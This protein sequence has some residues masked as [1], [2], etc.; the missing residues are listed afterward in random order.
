MSCS[1]SYKVKTFPSFDRHAKKLTKK[2]PSL[3]ADLK[4]LFDSLRHTPDQG[5]P[6]GK[7]CYKVR[8]P[9]SSKGQGK[10]GGARAITFVKVTR[11]TVFLL[12]LYDKSE[13]ETITAAKG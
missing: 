4:S 12:A 1:M 7:G 8:M 6:L 13:M 9:I 5:S 3:K 10:S 2:Y 11:N